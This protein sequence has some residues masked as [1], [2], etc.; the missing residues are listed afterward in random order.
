MNISMKIDWTKPVLIMSAQFKDVFLRMDGKGITAAN[1][2]G[3]GTVNCQKTLS[4]SGAFMAHEKGNDT[5]TFESMAFPGVYLRMDGGNVRSKA[6]AGAGTVNCQ[7]G[8]QEWEHFKLHRLSDGSYNIESAA[9]PNVY[10]RMDG[11]NPE[12]KEEGFGTVNCQF[13]A[14]SYERFYI[15][16]MPDTGKVQ[17]FLKELR[18]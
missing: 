9:F 13:G 17:D 18:K 10:L 6:D 15:L 14:A 1:G 2:S 5:F 4:I 11:N 8:A 16:N 7:F 12:G 3:A